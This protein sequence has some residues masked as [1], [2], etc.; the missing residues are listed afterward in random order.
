MSGFGSIH[1]RRAMNERQEMR[2]DALDPAGAT[3]SRAVDS[4]R[5][6]LLAVVALVAVSLPPITAVVVHDQAPAG[7]SDS[8][9]LV[10]IG[11][12]IVCA[13]AAIALG[14]HARGAAVVGSEL[15]SLSTFGVLLGI[16][17]LVAIVALMLF[18]LMVG[19]AASSWGSM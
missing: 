2:E 16:V 6:S 11:L 15:R 13:I 4:K 12:G 19:A 8:V 7:V 10:L 3:K 18:L 5:A 1:S 14:I 17:E 9:L